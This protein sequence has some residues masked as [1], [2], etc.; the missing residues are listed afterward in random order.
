[1]IKMITRIGAST[2]DFLQSLGRSFIFL[3]NTIIRFPRPIK[4]FPLLIEELYSVGVLSMV[5]IIVSGLFIGMVVALQGYNILDKFSASEELGQLVALSVVRELGPVVSALLFAGRAGSALT[6]EIGLM[7][8]T[9]QLASMEMM[10]VDPLWRVISPRFWAGFISMPLLSLIFSC[11]AI[12][13]GYLVGVVWLG[14]DNGTFWNN[15]QSAVSFRDDIV[16]GMIKSIVFGF[17]VVWIAVFQGFDTT[18]TAAGI[19]RSTTR[20]VVY[21]SLAILGLDFVLTAMMMGGW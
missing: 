3:F 13:G 7:K 17:V 8:A 6:A 19:G 5:I 9:D 11:V 20:T 16:N 2:L 4:T 18:P 15:M 14:V 12:Y 21:S 10:G 1:M